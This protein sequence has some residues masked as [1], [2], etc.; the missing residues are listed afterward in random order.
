VL[1]ARARRVRLCSYEPAGKHQ[2][3]RLTGQTL[4]RRHRAIRKLTRR[5]N[6]LPEPS[7]G[8]TACPFDDGSKVLALASYRHH[9]HA[10][11]EIKLRGCQTVTNGHLTRR[12]LAAHG[13]GPRLLHQV[14]RLTHRHK[15]HHH[16]RH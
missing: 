16:H 7:P 12:A 1:P 3:I 6:A 2:R 10:A 9:R 5:L 13:P 4:V 11:V 8:A 15:R 14:Q